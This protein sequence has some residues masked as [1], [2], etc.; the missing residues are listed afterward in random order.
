M[1]RCLLQVAVQVQVT[2]QVT[3]HAGGGCVGCCTSRANSHLCRL[4]GI[5][6]LHSTLAATMSCRKED[7]FLRAKLESIPDM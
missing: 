2:V 5:V 4:P 3:V 7:S 6:V 1:E